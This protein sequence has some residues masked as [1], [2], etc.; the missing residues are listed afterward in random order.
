MT[1]KIDLQHNG[2]QMELKC[3]KVPTVPGNMTENGKFGMSMGS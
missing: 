1:W 2:D 3:G